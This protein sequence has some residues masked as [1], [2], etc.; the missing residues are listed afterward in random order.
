MNVQEE[1]RRQMAI[2]NFEEGTPEIAESSYVSPTATV[3]GDVTIGERCYIGHGAILRS[4]YG[5]IVGEMGLVKHGQR[6]IS[7]RTSFEEAQA[8]W[9]L[10]SH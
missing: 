10:P 1:E 7:V 4:D 5:A 9:Y 3:I 8:A 6:V 2:Y